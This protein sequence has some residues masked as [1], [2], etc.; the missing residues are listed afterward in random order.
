MESGSVDVA[1][2]IQARTKGEARNF[3]F[4]LLTVS[5]SSLKNVELFGDFG[6][7]NDSVRILIPP[8][9]L[10]ISLANSLADISVAEEVTDSFLMN[11]VS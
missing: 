9:R 3:S 2:I 10:V 1:E 4:N 7:D 8:R 6:D 5:S 11:S